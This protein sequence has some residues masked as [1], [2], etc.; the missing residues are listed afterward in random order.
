MAGYIIFEYLLDCLR[1]MTGYIIFD[2]YY[3]W[4]LTDHITLDTWLMTDYKIFNVKMWL[5]LV[6]WADD[7]LHHLQFFTDKWLHCH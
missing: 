4:Y 5:Y 1:L 3:L 2:W 6:H 7:W